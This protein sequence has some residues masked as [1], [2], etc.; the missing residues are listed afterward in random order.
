MDGRIW[1]SR[2]WQQSEVSIRI[3]ISWFWKMAMSLMETNEIYF[4][5]ENR[6]LKKLEY[7]NH[8][9]LFSNMG[10]GKYGRK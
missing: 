2:K 6:I 5:D 10:E 1:D 8:L 9:G 3:K 7:V 4:I